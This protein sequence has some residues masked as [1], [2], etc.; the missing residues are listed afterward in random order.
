MK[1][2]ATFAIAMAVA[3]NSGCATVF[4]L[5]VNLP[6]ATTVVPAGDDFATQVLGN[7][8]DMGDST[9]IDMQESLG[10]SN[11]SIAGGMFSGTAAQQAS[12]IYP[13]F[14]GYANSINLSGGASHPIDTA[15]YR[16][17]TYKLRVTPTTQ[18]QYTRAIGVKDGG[19]YGTAPPT[20]AEGSY[21]APLPNNAWKIVSFDMVTQNDGKYYQWQAFPALTGL[22]IDP[23]NTN[24]AAPY[25]SRTAN[26]DWIRLTAP[27]TNAQK[28]S[29]VWTDSGY[30]GTYNI[31]ASDSGGTTFALGANI[32]GTSY[33]ADLSILPPGAY[34]ITVAR[35]DSSATANSATFH[36]NTPPQIVIA[37]PSTSGDLGQDFATTVVGNPWGPI[38]ANDFLPSIGVRNFTNVSY[39]NPVGTFYGRPVN[40]DPGWWFNLG[41]QTVDAGKYRSLCFALEVFGPRSVGSGSV[42]RFFWGSGTSQATTSLPI[43]L[44]DNFNDMVV[45]KYCMAD[46]AA[47]LPD[48][49]SPVYGNWV[50]AQSVFR[51]DPDEFTPPSGCSTQDTCHDVRLDSV[52]LSPFAL[53]NPSYT[54]KWTLTDPDSASDTV[55]VYLDPD[56]APL[57]GNEIHL[58]S[59]TMPTGNGQF[60]WS[61]SCANALTYGPWHVLVVA[62]DGINPVS[63][64][65]G[66]PILIS[67]YDGIFRNGFESIPANCP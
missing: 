24:A 35:S 10:L 19:S 7:P 6:N 36:I 61:G 55:D 20:V 23:A 60:A 50:G 39:S 57:N 1:R 26:L 49:S 48:P 17:V 54:F 52:T 38:N 8:W 67:R 40:H 53:A 4:A 58:G 44:D 41:S 5:G 51:I 27:A 18:P 25:T 64:Y 63:Q 42:A 47:Y 46:V 66:G 12:N 45:G 32:S 28:T 14:M 59:A 21:S 65:A 3:L 13:L 30:S 56:A 15:H 33:S 62:S 22:R 11:Q 31:S 29:V 43:P 2:H 34:T 9:D 37:T 16:Y